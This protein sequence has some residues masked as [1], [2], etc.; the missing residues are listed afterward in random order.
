MTGKQ[1][2][3]NFGTEKFLFKKLLLQVSNLKAV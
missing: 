1:P 2:R 3:S